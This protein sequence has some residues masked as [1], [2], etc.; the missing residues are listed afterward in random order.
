MFLGKEK[1]IKSIQNKEIYYNDGNR[2]K[3]AVTI[4]EIP[5]NDISIDVS[6]GSHFYLPESSTI[7]CKCCKG[8]KKIPFTY[9]RLEPKRYLDLFVEHQYLANHRSDTDNC[10]M[11]RSLSEHADQTKIKIDPGQTILA[12]TQEYIGT[13]VPWLTSMIQTKSTLARKGINIITS[14]GIASP[15]FHSRWTLEISNITNKTVELMPGTPIGQVYFIKIDG[16]CT[17]YKGKYSGDWSPEMML[18]K[19]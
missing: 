15:G 2:R 16:K 8:D 17:L 6:L 14:A 12:H 9:V 1:I 18:P 19:E 10:E 4:P 5:I 11:C 13:T 3:T 7:S